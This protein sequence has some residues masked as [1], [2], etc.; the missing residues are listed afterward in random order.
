MAISTSFLF[1]FQPY[2]HS[3][4]HDYVSLLFLSFLFVII[5]DEMHLEE[6]WNEKN[7]TLGNV[8]KFLGLFVQLIKLTRYSWNDVDCQTYDCSLLSLVSRILLWWTNFGWTWQVR[9]N[10]HGCRLT[11]DVWK[12]EISVQILKGSENIEKRA[13]TSAK[14]VLS[15]VWWLIDFFFFPPFFCHSSKRIVLSFIFYSLFII[16]LL[17]ICNIYIFV[18]FFSLNL[19][20]KNCDRLIL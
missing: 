15:T 19:S 3:T 6:V 5:F 9:S 18:F 8:I 7:N 2:F 1:V 4:V 20:Q 17:F 13:A 14:N 10:E 11:T 12:V 16:S